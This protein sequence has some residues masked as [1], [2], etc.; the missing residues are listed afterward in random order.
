[1]HKITLLVRRLLGIEV[2]VAAVTAPL[3]RMVNDLTE[4]QQR[5][6]ARMKENAVIADMLAAENQMLGRE[7]SRADKIKSSINELLN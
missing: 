4:V 1:M 3:E 7:I 2:D 5:H 6:A